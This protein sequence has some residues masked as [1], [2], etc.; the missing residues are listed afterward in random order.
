MKVWDVAETGRADNRRR[1]YNATRCACD[2]GESGEVG[3]VHWHDS[4]KERLR[5][6]HLHLR[7]ATG[8]IRG[9]Q[10]Q[11]QY[12]LLVNGHLVAVYVADFV[13]QEEET[14]PGASAPWGW[15]TVVEDVKA[16]PTR[17]PVYKLKRALMKALYGIEVRET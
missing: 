7:Q 14:L 11:V 15:A 4:L 10:R 5:C 13:Y 12:G 6:Y 9:L 8:E 3:T 17:T 16:P 2:C 1:K